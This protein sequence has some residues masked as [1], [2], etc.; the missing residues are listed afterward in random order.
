MYI[1]GFFEK[2][3]F[4]RAKLWYEHEPGSIV[5]NKDFEILL[6]FAIYCDHIIEAKR[7]DTVVVDKAK[8]Q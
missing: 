4:N 8:S 2:L 6:D 5:E 3:G 1:G 7:P